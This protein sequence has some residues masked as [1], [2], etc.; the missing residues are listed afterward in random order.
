MSNKA[1]VGAL[2]HHTLTLADLTCDAQAHIVGVSPA[3]EQPNDARKVRALSSSTTSS[4]GSGTLEL[5]LLVKKTVVIVKTIV[6]ADATTLELALNL[7]PAPTRERFRTSERGGKAP[8]VNESDLCCP[9]GGGIGRPLVEAAVE[10][11]PGKLPLGVVPPVDKG[12]DL[13]AGAGGRLSSNK[14]CKGFGVESTARDLREGLGD[15]LS[16]RKR[17]ADGRN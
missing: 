17:N 14:L 8:V 1:E 11:L 10:K 5:G 6:Q 15:A 7:L 2:I 12:S 16:H 13:L 9:R 3:A 4:Q